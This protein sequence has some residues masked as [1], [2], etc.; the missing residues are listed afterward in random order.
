VAKKRVSTFRNKAEHQIPPEEEQKTVEVKQ[1]D[2]SGDCNTENVKKRLRH[3]A[4]STIVGTCPNPKPEES[5]EQQ[6]AGPS[7]NKKG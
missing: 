7:R 6:T 3:G 5:A 2:Q 1:G 4:V